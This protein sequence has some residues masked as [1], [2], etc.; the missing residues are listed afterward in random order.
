[1]R[2]SID[3]IP[4]LAGIG[5]AAVALLSGCGGG[6]EGGGFA[7]QCIEYQNRVR[8]SNGAFEN[9]VGNVC[10]KQV[11]FLDSASGARLALAPGGSG[12]FISISSSTVFAACFAPEEPFEAGSS[13]FTCE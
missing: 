4:A 9:T 2:K 12:V 1:M 7:T 8:L 5:I 6:T 10:D 11:N 13:Q 3:K